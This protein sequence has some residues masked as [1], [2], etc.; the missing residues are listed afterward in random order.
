MTDCS[1]NYWP[2]M[3]LLR[4]P[5]QMIYASPWPQHLYPDSSGSF[6][7]SI[8]SRITWDGLIEWQLFYLSEVEELP[9][10]IQRMTSVDIV[11]VHWHGRAEGFPRCWVSDW[12]RGVGE[13]GG[14]RRKP[15]FIGEIAQMDSRFSWDSS[16]PG[17]K[18]DSG[19]AVVADMLENGFEM[20]FRYWGQWSLYD[21]AWNVAVGMHNLSNNHRTQDIAFDVWFEGCLRGRPFRPIKQLDVN[22]EELRK[23]RKQMF[24]EL[25]EKKRGVGFPKEFPRG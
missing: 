3:E 13:L 4:Q 22:V 24:Q 8:I 7:D 23:R 16:T 10:A 14:V 15:F 17:G 19:A 1:D 18:T 2:I 12:F 6:V 5:L 11:V 20:V 9:Q 21:L 25:L